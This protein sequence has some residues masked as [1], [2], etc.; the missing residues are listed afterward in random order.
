MLHDFGWLGGRSAV[1]V[2]SLRTVLQRGQLQPNHPLPLDQEDTPCPPPHTHTHTKMYRD[3]YIDLALFALLSWGSESKTVAGRGRYL[4]HDNPPV[5][6]NTKSKASLNDFVANQMNLKFFEA[7]LVT[8]GWAKELEGQK[9]HVVQFDLDEEASLF[10]GLVAQEGMQSL[11][12]NGHADYT[13]FIPTNDA[14]VPMIESGNPS[15]YRSWED[16][17]LNHIVSNHV[18]ATKYMEPNVKAGLATLSGTEVDMEYCEGQYTVT[19]A[20]RFTDFTV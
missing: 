9:H 18:Q 4:R 12:M 10:A 20:D 8:T 2:E 3:T 6:N 13:L 15:P 17:I 5:E 11:L 16:L 1:P 19:C 14:L 7:A